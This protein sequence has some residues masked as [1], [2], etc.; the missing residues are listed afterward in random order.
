MGEGITACTHWGR[1]LA[2]QILDTSLGSIRWCPGPYLLGAWASW[3]GTK[4]DSSM[5]GVGNGQSSA[6]GGQRGQDWDVGI[7]WSGVRLL[8]RGGKDKR[9]HH[10]LFLQSFHSLCFSI[11]IAITHTPT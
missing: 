3:G 1:Q 9:K 7:L 2:L 8:K 10:V 11:S 5:E 6:G 4:K